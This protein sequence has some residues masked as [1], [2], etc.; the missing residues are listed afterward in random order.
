MYKKCKRAKSA[1]T[2]ISVFLHLMAGENDKSLKWPMRGT[3]SIELL[4]Q[5]EDENHKECSVHF[6]QTKSQSWNSKVSEGRSPSGWGHQNFVNYQDLKGGSFYSQT[7]Y[8]KDD[9]LYFR[10]TMTENR[11]TSK[12]WLAGAVPS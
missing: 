8:L 6:D 3:F 12:P 7:Q 1:Y 10:V 4:N 5:K 11:S 2:G 9:T